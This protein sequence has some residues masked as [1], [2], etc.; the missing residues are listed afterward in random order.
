MTLQPTNLKG[1]PNLYG[2]TE[3]RLLQLQKWLIEQTKMLNQILGDLLQSRAEQLAIKT[4]L[5]TLEATLKGLAS[6][7]VPTGT[8][9][10]TDIA[11][12]NACA[13]LVISNPPTQAQVQAILAAVNALGAMT[14][15]GPTTQGAVN[16]II[17]ALG[18]IDAALSAIQESATPNT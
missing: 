2:T 17:T 14:V 5:A 15:Y 8:A 4:T 6:Q 16:T 10:A 7:T 9:L 18:Q 13:S 11:S 12:V 1:L 3:Q